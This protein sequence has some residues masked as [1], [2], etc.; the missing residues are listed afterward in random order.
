MDDFSIQMAKFLI[1]GDNT[2][3]DD[4]RFL[5]ARGFESSSL[6]S[7]MLFLLQFFLQYGC[8]WMNP[9]ATV[10]DDSWSSYIL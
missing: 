6:L 5:R 10:T 3:T 1:S 4:G 9:G 2:S 8:R 7:D